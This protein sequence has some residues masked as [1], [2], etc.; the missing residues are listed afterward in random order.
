MAAGTTAQFT[1]L[2]EIIYV[3][4]VLNTIHIQFPTHLSNEYYEN[5]YII[6]IVKKKPLNMFKYNYLAVRIYF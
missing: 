6:S 1:E 5:G 4:S 3:R 2:L